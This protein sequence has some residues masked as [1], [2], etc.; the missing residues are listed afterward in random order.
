MLDAISILK[1]P[2]QIQSSSNIIFSDNNIQNA[3]L[4]LFFTEVNE[5]L[6]SIFNLKT[7]DIDKT[8]SLVYNYIKNLNPQANYLKYAKEIFIKI[9][10]NSYIELSS[11]KIDIKQDITESKIFTSSFFMKVIIAFICA[12]LISIF[13]IFIIDYFKKY[14]KEIVNL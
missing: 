12:L 1:D 5:N 13:L 4:V 10:E 8:Y 2:I 6:I 7:N 9:C 11:L 3:E 14:G